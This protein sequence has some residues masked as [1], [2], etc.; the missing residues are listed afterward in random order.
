MPGGIGGRRRLV[1]VLIFMG[2]GRAKR[3][4]GGLKSYGEGKPQRTRTNFRGLTPLDTMLLV[5]KCRGSFPNIF[6]GL[7]A[8]D[9]H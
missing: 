9:S 7:K 3:R 4:G 1:V 2:L 8:Y 6:Y 5:Q